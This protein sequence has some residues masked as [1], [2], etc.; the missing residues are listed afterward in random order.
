MG[1]YAM[2]PAVID[3]IAPGERIDFPDLISR[4]MHAG[5]DVQTLQYSGYWRDI[6]NRSDYEEAIADF[7]SAPDHFLGGQ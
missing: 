1:V 3:L 7:E 4:A 5:H 6:G 2:E